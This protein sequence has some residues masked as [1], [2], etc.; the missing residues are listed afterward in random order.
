MPK[1]KLAFDEAGL[2]VPTEKPE[3]ITVPLAEPRPVAPFD[4]RSGWVPR[5]DLAGNSIP[6]GA[7]DDRPKA[8][9]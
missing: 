9:P 8:K 7:P 5:P 2:P 3:N 4:E 6:A 1:E